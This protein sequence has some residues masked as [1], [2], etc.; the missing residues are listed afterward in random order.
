V[1]VR[2]IL[3][4]LLGTLPATDLHAQ[5]FF[6]RAAACRCE[7]T[8]KTRKPKFLLPVAGIGFLPVSLAAR[9]SQPPMVAI[10]SIVDIRADDTPRNALEGERALEVGALAPDT[11]TTLPTLMVFASLLT[12]AGVY[13]LIPHRRRR[14]RSWRSRSG[15]P[16]HGVWRLRSVHKR[17]VGTAFALAGGLLLVLGSREYAEGAQA[18]RRARAEW[19]RDF[20]TPSL[21]SGAEELVPTPRR[22]SEIDTSTAPAMAQSTVTDGASAVPLPLLA[23]S[24]REIRR[25]T[26]VARLT[27]EAIGLDEIVLEGVGPVELNGGPGHF[28]GSVLPGG[29]G[30]SILS[31]HRDRHFRRVGE[32]AVGAKLRT[33][34]RRGVVDWVVTERRIVSKDTPSLFEESKETLTLTTCWPLRYFGPAPDR[35]LIIA[36]PAT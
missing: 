21:A 30:N 35:L 25:G 14:L 23:M 31:A 15:Q 27:I 20:E 6:R 28:P 1:P 34:T 17:R 11:A 26:P 32:L 4:L 33:E 16:R 3:I 29:T 10:P 19:L 36:K 13:L 8:G 7:P 24:G 2:L 18:Q 22:M 5:R 12:L 9:D